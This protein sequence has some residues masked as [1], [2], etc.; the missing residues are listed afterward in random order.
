MAAGQA[1]LVVSD[2]MVREAIQAIPAFQ[3]DGRFD[4]QR[5]QLA[6]AS[7]VPAQTPAQFDRLVRDGLQNTLVA[8]AVAESNFVTASEMERLIRLM[9]ERR[10]VN[11]LVVP[12]AEVDATSAIDDAQIQAW[13]D[14]HQGDYL[15][16]ESVSL[17]YV[18]LDASTMPAPPPAHEASRNTAG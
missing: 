18:E 11:L 13:Y 8:S 4:L 3:V 16:P 12:P 15:A 6:L 2:A 5:Y 10:D 7:Q 14:S 1:G 9:G 17:E